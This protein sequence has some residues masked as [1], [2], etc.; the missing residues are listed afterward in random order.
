MECIRSL[1]KPM[2]VYI[3]QLDPLN[4]Y[5]PQFSTFNTTYACP[6]HRLMTKRSVLFFINKDCRLFITLQK[7]KCQHVDMTIPINNNTIQYLIKKYVIQYISISLLYS[8]YCWYIVLLFQG[9]VLW[10]K[11]CIIFIFL[12][13]SW[14]DILK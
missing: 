4:V 8:V 5:I 1:G 7:Y 12:Q 6:F 11:K 13:I 10:Y 9:N 3:R 2:K 14:L